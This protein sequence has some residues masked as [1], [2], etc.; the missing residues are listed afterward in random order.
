VLAANVVQGDALKMQTV[1]GRPIEF[2]EWAYLGR[3]KFQ[4]RDFAYKD[5]TQRSLAG[6]TLFDQFDEDELFAPVRTYPVM[7]VAQIAERH[8][9]QPGRG[10]ATD[11]AAE[12]AAQTS[13]ESER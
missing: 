11:T 12:A 5:L 8:D 13:A 9:A 4:R 7:T 6:G 10:Q 1:D 3:G 2:A